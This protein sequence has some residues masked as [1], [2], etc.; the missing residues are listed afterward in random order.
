MSLK[1]KSKQKQRAFFYSNANSTWSN[2]RGRF[3]ELPSTLA[4][5]EPDVLKKAEAISKSFNG[6][7]WQN[8]SVPER[9]AV[10]ELQSSPDS[11]VRICNVDKGIN[12]GT[13]IA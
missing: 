4:P 8:L 7:K 11:D 6:S 9:S 12:N 10:T 3:P 5:F 13:G 2:N 1:D